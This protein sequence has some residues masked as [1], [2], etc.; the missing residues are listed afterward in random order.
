ME[1]GGGGGMPPELRQQA[2]A[3]VSSVFSHVKLVT[4]CWNS[5]GVSLLCVGPLCP[6]LLHG[7]TASRTK[8]FC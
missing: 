6:D 3:P 8:I 2:E 5:T 7:F 1:R 4:E